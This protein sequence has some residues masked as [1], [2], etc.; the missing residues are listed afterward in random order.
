MIQI[1]KQF[2][3]MTVLM[4]AYEFITEDHFAQHMNKTIIYNK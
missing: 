3:T 2:D 4:N 1:I